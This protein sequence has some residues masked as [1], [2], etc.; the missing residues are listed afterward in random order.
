MHGESGILATIQCCM[1]PH[2]CG[3]LPLGTY[4]SDQRP[5]RVPEMTFLGSEYKNTSIKTP[6]QDLKNIFRNTIAKKSYCFKSL[7]DTFY[8][9]EF[10]QIVIRGCGV[11]SKL[12][13]YCFSFLLNPGSPVSEYRFVVHC[14]D[15][16]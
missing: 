8:T 2:C 1:Q 10:L 9:I 16:E 5:G 11:K 7:Y 14:H 3:S 6:F 4:W 15:E 13:S 12:K